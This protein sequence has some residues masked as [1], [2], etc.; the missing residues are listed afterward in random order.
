MQKLSAEVARALGM[1]QASA[2]A[3]IDVY[4]TS[5]SFRGEA[6]QRIAFKDLDIGQVEYLGGQNPA[7]LMAQFDKLR[8]EQDYDATIVLTDGSGYELGE[9]ITE[10]RVPDFPVWLVHLGNQIP[11]GYDDQTMAALQGSQGGVA[12]SLEEA[13][14]RIAAGLENA[15]PAGSLLITQDLVDGYVWQTAPVQS[16]T[17]VELVDDGFSALAARRVILAEMQRQRGKLEDPKTLDQL[18]ALA[19]QQSIVTPYSSMIVLVT[20]RQE[21]LLKQ[22]SSLDDR[23]LREVEG[24]GET[25]PATQLPLSGVP[26]PEEWLLIGLALV[27]A[28]YVWFTRGKL[29]LRQA[30]AVVQLKD[31]TKM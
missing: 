10:L 29:R 13:M 19:Q 21:S 12:G 6:P 14:L 18:H 27:M 4:L 11:I 1:L 9:S 20:E 2:A 16:T 17:P 24:L 7:E 3:D 26:E 28:V 31:H 25:T 8:G 5:S 23:Y 30:S 15:S 22:L